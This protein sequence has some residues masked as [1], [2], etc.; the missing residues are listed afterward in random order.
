MVACYVGTDTA[1]LAALDGGKTLI[2]VVKG[3]DFH[4]D[5]SRLALKDLDS[6]QAYCIVVWKRLEDEEE[7]PTAYEIVNL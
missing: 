6:D 3:D 4:N 5:I 1:F 7:E 2:T